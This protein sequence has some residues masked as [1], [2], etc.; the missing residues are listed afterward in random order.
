VQLGGSPNLNPDG[1]VKR[2]H[3][4]YVEGDNLRSMVK[5]DLIAERVAIE[6]YSEMVRYIGDSDPTTRRMLEGILANEEKH[7]E[8][9]ASLFANPRVTPEE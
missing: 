3:A 1:L 4:E 9:L 6:C 7:A 5:E 8:D 2:S